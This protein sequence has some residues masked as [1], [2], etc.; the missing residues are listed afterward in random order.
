MGL[1]KRERL[2]QD[3]LRL[4]R[5][6]AKGKLPIGKSEGRTH[7]WHFEL[8]LAGV[9]LY[10]SDEN[11]AR[12]RRRPQELLPISRARNNSTTI[13]QQEYCE[14]AAIVRC[15]RTAPLHTS[16]TAMNG[17]CADGLRYGQLCELCSGR[18]SSPF[19]HF[20]STY[21]SN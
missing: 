7:Q 21:A 18:C 9:M 20:P 4:T 14:T 10:V 3:S 12:S 15:A 1:S 19:S 16:A 13:T 5:A 2:R 11:R 8:R 17:A 6:A